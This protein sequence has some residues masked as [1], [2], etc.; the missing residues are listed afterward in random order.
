METNEAGAD[1]T[2]LFRD[3]VLHNLPDDG[4]GVRARVIVVV[5][6]EPCS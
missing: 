6:V 5:Q 4:L 3:L 2:A 1:A